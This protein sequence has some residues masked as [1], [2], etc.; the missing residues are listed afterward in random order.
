MIVIKKEMNIE[1]QE[2]QKLAWL[3][4]FHKK[5]MFSHAQITNQ[6]GFFKLTPP[7]DSYFDKRRP[8]N[9]RLLFDDDL[10]DGQ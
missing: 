3:F 2:K 6:S 8:L 5:V 4:S 7:A 10:C 1:F 9:D